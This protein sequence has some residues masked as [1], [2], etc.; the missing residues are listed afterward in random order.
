MSIRLINKNTGWR[1]LSVICPRKGARLRMF[2]SVAFG[3]RPRRNQHRTSQVRT[4]CWEHKKIL[5]VSVVNVSEP[6]TI[7]DRLQFN[8]CCQ[9]IKGLLLSTWKSFCF[10]CWKLPWQWE[11]IV[12]L[13]LSCFPHLSHSIEACFARSSLHWWLRF[14]ITYVLP[15]S[16][17]TKSFFCCSS[18]G[19]N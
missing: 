16:P 6:L 12:S 13:P 18:V 5:D 4:S 3:L 15:M 8:V 17:T 11:I 7:N 19:Q 2:E 14:S 9:Q 10:V 1:V